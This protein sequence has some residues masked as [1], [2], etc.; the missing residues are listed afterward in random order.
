MFPDCSFC[1]CHFNLHLT[2]LLKPLVQPALSVRCGL[3]GEQVQLNGHNTSTLVTRCLN[4][5]WAR[6]GIRIIGHFRIIKL[7]ST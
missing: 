6:A 3:L 4:W 7:M 1:S 2:K 5:A